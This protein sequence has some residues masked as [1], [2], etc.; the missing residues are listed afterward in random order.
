MNIQYRK[1]GDYFIPDWE[2]PE[3]QQ[4]PLGLYGRLRRKYLEENRSGLYTRMILTGTLY[5]HLYET[6]SAAQERLDTILPKLAAAAGA[7]EALKAENPMKWVTLMN[8]CK[9]QVEEIIFTE[10]IYV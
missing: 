3:S 6:D 9:A 10:L 1:E 8:A 7:T 5:D 2:I 4:K